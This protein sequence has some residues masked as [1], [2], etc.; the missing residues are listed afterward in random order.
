MRRI[1]PYHLYELVHGIQDE[2]RLLQDAIG[3]GVFQEAGP[4]AGG[5]A[6]LEVEEVIANEDRLL[7]LHP[8]PLQSQVEL[9]PGRL[10]PGV[11]PGDDGMEREAELAAG[12]IHG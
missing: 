8:Q 10:G 7:P 9:V 6:C 12:Y 4:Y 5:L 1:L 2:V 3:V 11:L